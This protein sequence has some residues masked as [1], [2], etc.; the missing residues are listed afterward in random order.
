MD[1]NTTLP[2][3]A[4]QT[5]IQSMTQLTEELQFRWDRRFRA[6]AYV[7][8]TVGTDNLPEGLWVIFQH[9]TPAELACGLVDAAHMTMDNFMRGD[10]AD[11][12]STSG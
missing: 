10:V 1:H 9:D 4:Y 11:V 8:Y 5:I 2:R 7:V 6:G 12:R 3:G